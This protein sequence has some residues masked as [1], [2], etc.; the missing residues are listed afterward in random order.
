MLPTAGLY[1]PQTLH[2]HND[3]PAARRAETK[4][5][6]LMY[7]QPQ[8][9]QPD[10]AG[11][12]A[13]N[14][15]PV[16]LARTIATDPEVFSSLGTAFSF[17][18]FVSSLDQTSNETEALSHLIQHIR[19][20]D[21]EASRLYTSPAVS[22]FLNIYPDHKA[23]IVTIRLDLRRTLNDIGAYVEAVRVID[24][25]GGPLG[26]RQ[27][28]EWVANHQETLQDRQQALSASHQQLVHAIRIMTTVEQC[29]W[30]GQDPIL[31]APVRPWI[32]DKRRDNPGSPYSRR[33]AHRTM[34]ASNITFSDTQEGS[35]NG[36]TISLPVELPGSAPDDLSNVDGRVS[37]TLNGSGAPNK[38]EMTRCLSVHE[39]DSRHMALDRDHD[40]SELATSPSQRHSSLEPLVEEQDNHASDQCF[41]AAITQ[42]QVR[43]EQ[44]AKLIDVRRSSYPNQ[45]HTTASSNPRSRTS[46]DTSDVLPTVI[47][48]TIERNDSAISTK[49]T[50]VVPV[51]PKRYRPR[52]S[53]TRRT[54]KSD[55]S[56]SPEL[57]YFQSQ[58]SLIDD[59]AAYMSPSETSE[60]ETCYSPTSSASALSSPRFPLSFDDVPSET[61]TS[62]L[63]LAISMSMMSLDDPRRTLSLNSNPSR[64]TRKPLPS[65]E[66]DLSRSISAPAGSS[67]TTL[68]RSFDMAGKTAAFSESGEGGTSFTPFD[69]VSRFSPSLT[70][71]LVTVPE[72]RGLS[73]T[74]YNMAPRDDELWFLQHTLCKQDYVDQTE[75]ST[76]LPAHHDNP[77]DQGKTLMNSTTEKARSPDQAP[78]DTNVSINKELTDEH[79][80][81][82]NP[83]TSPTP[84]SLGA[85]PELSISRPEV[86]LI[87]PIESVNDIFS[88]P[89]SA[90]LTA[91]AKRRAAH[92]RRMQRSFGGG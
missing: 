39:L 25:D 1:L 20:D 73:P 76:N 70:A 63:G 27:R 26:Q 57:P 16:V 88:P 81:T 58:S 14:Q 46:L 80:S 54:R 15:T 8:S 51:R 69:G 85:P 28:F 87:S 82:Q 89:Q 71:P 52:S 53:E 4:G 48:K 75:I 42:K 77:I 30:I 3:A 60:V 24:D 79:L 68:L 84:T 9:R 62:N 44:K 31:K 64:V 35:M 23:E 33:P 21:A 49:A 36:S 29:D 67:K 83:P 66:V 72:I 22:R 7:F 65:A 90:L 61:L 17:A 40:A 56:L 59:L 18:E 19:R 10:E 43:Q 5:A 91:Q 86:T 78:H 12:K 55:G 2:R 47:E 11:S 13:A 37:F 6:S 50:V 92:T 38:D 45:S 74:V 32:M 34:S 41:G